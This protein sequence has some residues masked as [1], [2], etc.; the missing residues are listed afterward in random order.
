MTVVMLSFAG[1]PPTAGFVG[2]VAVFGAAWR[3]GY[4]WLVLVAVAMSLVTAF[5]YLRV[6]VVMYFRAPIEVDDHGESVEESGA[7]EQPGLGTQ[8]VIVVG[9]VMSV[10]LGL[11][12]GWLI[13]IA[14][15]AVQLLR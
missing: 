7:A 11:A 10:V 8:I 15:S 9:T 12:P 4:W 2:K 1:I 3:G 13:D 14:T 5:F 6:I